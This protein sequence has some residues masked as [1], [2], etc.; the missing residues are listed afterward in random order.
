MDDMIENIDELRPRMEE[1]GIEIDDALVENAK[2]ARAEW[3]QLTMSLKVGLLPTFSFMLRQTTELFY[4]FRAMAQIA[5]TFTLRNLLTTSPKETYEELLSIQAQLKSSLDGMALATPSAKK[6]TQA[7]KQSAIKEVSESSPKL[8]AEA[9]NKIG[10]FT[11]RAGEELKSI[12]QRQLS[13]LKS[14]EQNTAILKKG[15][16]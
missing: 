16:A 6:T 4:A 7:G 3:E 2:Q 10:G 13:Q 5:N 15:V 8:F 14:I 12:Q 9:L 1:L 11:G